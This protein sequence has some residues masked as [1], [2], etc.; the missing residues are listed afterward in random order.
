M[1]GIWPYVAALIPSAGVGVLFWV[2][3]KNMMEGDRKER[4]AHSQWDAAHTQHDEEN[5][6]NSTNSEA[7]HKNG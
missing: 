7:D 5:S 1:S 6:D 2:V 3:I 4:L